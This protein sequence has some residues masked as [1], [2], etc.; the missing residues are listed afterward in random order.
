VAGRPT[1]EHG[2]SLEGGTATLSANSVNACMRPLSSLAIW[3]K[4]IKRRTSVVGMFPTRASVIRF[5]GM[6]LAEP[7]DEW[8]DSRRF[9]HPETMALIDAKAA[10]KE[11]SPALLMASSSGSVGDGPV[12]VRACRRLSE[13]WRLAGMECSPSTPTLWYPVNS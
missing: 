1:R 9:F 10:E 4:E 6:I 8:Q 7:D 5:V 11:V 2:H 3:P 12:T 13:G